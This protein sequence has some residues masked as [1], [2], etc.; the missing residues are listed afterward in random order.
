MTATQAQR[1]PAYVRRGNVGASPEGNIKHHPPDICTT[2]SR[3]HQSKDDLAAIKHGGD[4][5]GWG[6]MELCR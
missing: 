1:G 3:L 2:F 6:G 5:E 4:V